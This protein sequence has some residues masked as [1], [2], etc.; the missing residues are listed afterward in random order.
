MW[1]H[2]SQTEN[3][4]F[5]SNYVNSRAHLIKSS[6]F[7]DLEGNSLKDSGHEESDQTDSE[8]DVQRGLYCDTA[9]NDV[10]NTSVTSMGSQVPEQDQ[11]EG[12]HCRE[13]CR[14]L[15]HSDRCWMPRNPVPSRAKSPEHGRNV[16]SLSIEAT[17]VDT[18][19]YE[20]CSTKRTFATFGK[21]G[22]EPV[23]EERG[24][25][26]SKGKRTVDPPICSPKVNG[27][28]REAGNGCEAVSPIMSPIHLKSPLSGKPSVSY[29]VM[30]CPGSRDLEPFVNNGPSRPIEAEPR[31]A[32]SENI[33]HEINPLLQECREKDSP[34]VK[35]LKDIVL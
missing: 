16:V 8:H 9:V 2:I 7:K 31:G 1:W 23:S 20:D 13:E 28:V 33:M 11:S 4:S 17:T 22:S 10:L 15:G 25:V 29:N 35:R 24:P 26:N 19:L 34:G 5:D 27:A 18:E 12:F 32:D 3:Y 14:I 30:H 21:E 6:T